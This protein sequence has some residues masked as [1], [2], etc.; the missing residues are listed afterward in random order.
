[1]TENGSSLDAQL[2][3]APQWFTWLI[4]GEAYS[5]YAV[6]GKP[7]V[8]ET[9]KGNTAMANQEWGAAQEHFEE[10]L[11]AD[12]GDLLARIGLAEIAQ[13]EGHFEVAEGTL[14]QTI[15]EHDLP[16]L[17]YRLGRLYAQQGLLDE[18][19]AEFDV[20]RRGAPL[21][22]RFQIA[23]GDVC[24]SDGREECAEL[25]FKTAANLQSWPDQGSRLIA[26][27]AMWR[28]RGDTERA[29]PLYEQAA[30]E[31]PNEYNLFVLVSVYRELG[32]FDEAMDMMQSMRMLYPLSPEVITIQADL[33]AA[34]KDYESAGELLRYAILL[35]ELRTQETTVSHLALGDVLLAQGNVEEAADEIAYA[36]SQNSYSAAGHTLR[37]ELAVTRNDNEGAIRAYQRAFELDPS[38]VGVYVALSNELRQK[39][40]T[41]ND[42]MVLLQ[43]ALREEADEPTLLLA[44]GDQWQRLGETDAAI[45]AYQAALEQ[46]APYSQGARPQPLTLGNSRAFAFSRVAATYEDQGDIEAAMNYYRSAIVA[47][48]D[49]SWTHLL[50]GDALRRQDDVNKAVNAYETALSLDES[51]V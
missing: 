33:E 4:D 22:A 48:P 51:E 28:Q 37:G 5:L 21:V 31:Q 16:V 15:S 24:L 45:D 29:L 35:Q 12:E 2:Q 19:I 40:G 46:L 49:A 6:S 34:Q 44:L 43:I 9:I 50:Y 30:Q 14:R 18:S 41:P 47:A 32:L 27:A 20:A 25:L 7:T 8:T 38:Q 10:A 11:A 3:L 13:R 36:L 23:L 1:M 39:G 17:H 42:V 26:E